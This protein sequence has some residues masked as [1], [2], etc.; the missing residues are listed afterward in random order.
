MKLNGKKIDTANFEY[1]VIPRQTGDL[2]FKC[3]AILEYKHFDE[4]VPAPKPSK[5]ML[6]GGVMKEDPDD[7]TYKEAMKHYAS[8]RY[9]YIVI[10]S[11]Q[12][13]DG[14][15]WETVKYTDPNTWLN[16]ET[17]LRE[18]KFTIGEINALQLGIA[19]ASSLNQDKLEEARNR[20]LASLVE[21]PKEL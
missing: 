5:I 12:A 9:A 6:P 19:T 11:L 13:T 1:V 16:W 18:A 4:L 17:E 21:A 7:V 20:F 3:Q 14:L 2:V 10:T 15:E 8:L